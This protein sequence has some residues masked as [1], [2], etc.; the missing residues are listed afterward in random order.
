MSKKWLFWVISEISIFGH[1]F[2][3]FFDTCQNVLPSKPVHKWPIFDKNRILGVSK[4][5]TFWTPFWIFGDPPKSG[6]WRGSPVLVIFCIFWHFW[7]KKG[8]PQWILVL[9]MT[10]LDI[11]GKRK[12]HVFYRFWEVEPYPRLTQIP[13]FS[14]FFTTCHFW[15]ADVKSQDF[16]NRLLSIFQMSK[17]TRKNP[18]FRFWT[19]IFRFSTP[20]EVDILTVEYTQIFSK[21]TFFHFFSKSEKTWFLVIFLKKSLFWTSFD[22]V[23]PP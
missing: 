16:A 23:P 17:N 11:F 15:S 4:N 20:S 19:P 2:D 7:L 22:I 14:P 1:F 5:D 12:M 8:Q 10:L 21:M 6:F 18:V 13:E 9:Q 3:P